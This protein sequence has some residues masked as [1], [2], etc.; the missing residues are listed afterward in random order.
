I[1]LR[2]VTLLWLSFPQQEFFYHPRREAPSLGRVDQVLKPSPGMVD[3]VRRDVPTNAR[4]FKLVFIENLESTVRRDP[5][6]EEE[7]DDRFKRGGI[8][9][10]P[11]YRLED[12]G[13]VPHPG[14]VRAIDAADIVGLIL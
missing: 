13:I 6:I 14:P 5:E 1:P 7:V 8:R 12:V 9:A 2:S 11:S 4:L 3:L 10:V